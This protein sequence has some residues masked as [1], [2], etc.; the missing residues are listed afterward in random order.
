M[1]ARIYRLLPD[2]ASPKVDN[3]TVKSGPVVDCYNHGIAMVTKD[4]LIAEFVEKG[5]EVNK[6]SVAGTTVTVQC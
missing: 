3:F 6:G 4:C 2:S 5:T 1:G